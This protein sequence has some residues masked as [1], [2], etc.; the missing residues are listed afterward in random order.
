MPVTRGV[1]AGGRP[2]GKGSRSGR[3][4]PSATTPR[5][6]AKG[7]LSQVKESIRTRNKIKIKILSSH[8]VFS[9]KPK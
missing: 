7:P 2:P 9:A 6:S 5:P 3:G 4:P 8:S 1:G